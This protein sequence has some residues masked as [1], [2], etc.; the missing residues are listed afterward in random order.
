MGTMGAYL[1]TDLAAVAPAEHVAD[2]FQSFAASCEAHVRACVERLE[3]NRT[4]N[5]FPEKLG[6][7]VDILI[8]HIS[9]KLHQS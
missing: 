5:N 3:A 1:E 6:L 9:T 7:K 2:G 4:T 8:D